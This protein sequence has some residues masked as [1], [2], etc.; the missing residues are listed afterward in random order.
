MAT[1]APLTE[2][3]IAHYTSDFF[4]CMRGLEMRRALWSR[5]SYNPTWDHDHCTFCNKEISDS[6]SGDVLS[7]G[8]VDSGDNAWV[9]ARCFEALKHHFEWVL[10]T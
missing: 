8:Y 3:Q 6:P 9:C 1:E 5:P 10:R 7:W 2:G 4:E